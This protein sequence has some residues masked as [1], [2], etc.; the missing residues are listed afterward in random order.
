MLL[1]GVERFA[2]ESVKTR[3]TDKFLNDTLGELRF[4]QILRAYERSGDAGQSVINYLN[5]SD[6]LKLAR[7]GDS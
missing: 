7:H 3:M 2:L 5:I 4:T 6:M 1:E